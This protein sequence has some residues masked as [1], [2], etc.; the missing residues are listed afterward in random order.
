MI[1]FYSS[2]ERQPGIRVHFVGGINVTLPPGGG[3]TVSLY[4][5]D[6]G[7]MSA[8]ENADGEV[9]FPF[10]WLEGWEV[11][12]EKAGVI[13]HRH[14]FNPA[15]R[16]V[17]ISLGSSSMGDTIA[18][19]PYIE[20]FQQKWGCYVIACTHH[21][22]W[23]AAAYPMMEWVPPGT[24]VKNL[25]A[26]TTIGWFYGRN[27][28]V[29]QWRCP[30]DFRFDPLQSTAAAQLGVSSIEIRPRLSIA[31][32][33]RGTKKRYV[34]I[35]VHSTA[36]AKYWNREGGW[37]AVVGWL[38]SRGFDV[39]VASREPDGWMGNKLPK[40]ARRLPD[41]DITTTATWIKHAEAFVGVGSGL[42]WLAWAMRVPT[43]IISGFSEEWTEMQ[44]DGVFRVPNS[45]TVCHGC[46]NRHRLAAD[47]W[48]W[49]PDRDGSAKFECTRAITPDAVITKTREALSYG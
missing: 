24:G 35:G 40:A 15:G 42:S 11:V 2:I 37:D 38:V 28:S 20:A 21:N 4:R 7:L 3:Y 5:E 33:G 46:F 17:L 23:L 16:R 19:I 36:Q 26:L 9:K 47:K 29:D 10:R 27:D 18:W 1:D 49:C 32:G 44:G 48:D 30:R 43:V 6:G 14:R 39:Y 31:T 41:Y 25:Y 8:V 45:G 34:C 12:V 22:D 13:C